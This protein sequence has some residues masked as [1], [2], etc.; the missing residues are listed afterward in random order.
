MFTEPN[1]IQSDVEYDDSSDEEV[2]LKQDLQKNESE[3]SLN[4]AHMNLSRVL[5]KSLTRMGLTAPTPIQSRAIPFGLMGKDIVAS[6]VTGSGKTLAFLIPIIE[7]LLYKPKTASIRVLILCPTRE[8]GVQSFEVLQQLTVETKITSAIAVGGLGLKS[9]ESNL[10]KQP[11]VLIATPGR[12]I[13]FVKNL[14]SFVL[15]DVEV[16]V[17]DE[18][19]RMLDAGF[20]KELNEIISCTQSCRQTML[21]SATMTDDVQQLVRLTLKNPV[22]LFVD[23][24]TST[25]ENLVQE[26]IR[27]RPQHE[28]SRLAITLSL[29]ERVY[30]DKC[31]VF[32]KTKRQVHDAFLYFREF[33]INAAEI[34]GNL[35]QSKRLESLELFKNDK[36]THLLATNVAARGL[37]ISGVKT[38]INC[39]MPESLQSYLHRVGRTA[40]AGKGGTSVSLCSEKD[41]WLLK[42]IL[43]TKHKTRHRVISREEILKTVERVNEVKSSINHKK[44]EEEQEQELKQVDMLIEK[45]N[46]LEKYAGE[47][48]SRPKRKFI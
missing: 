32:F 15:D 46:N 34:H 48:M 14:A 29:C 39:E 9:Q 21:F 43:Q 31:I 26:F 11:D 17:I 44:R 1:T 24:P 45:T 28:N 10:K 22:K 19:D 41:R 25:S 13:D 33:N 42:K 6:A 20:E 4:F 2:E 5:V 23:E 36:V 30:K 40:R 7:R 8:L 38:V 16:L 37:D 12:L 35:T 27:I 18:A 47:I 3:P